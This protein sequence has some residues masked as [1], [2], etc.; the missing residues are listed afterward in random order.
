MADAVAV[1][2]TRENLLRNP[3]FAHPIAP[4]FWNLAASGSPSLSG[5]LKVTKDSEFSTPGVLQRVALEPGAAYRLD[6]DLV[7]SDGCCLWAG[8]G[9]KRPLAIHAADKSAKGL[10]T[11][12]VR[13]RAPDDGRAVVGMLF[14]SGVPKGSSFIVHEAR[15]SRS[16]TVLP[17]IGPGYRYGSPVVAGMASIPGRE[18]ILPRVVRSL[19]DQID[20]FVVYLNNYPA[21]PKCLRDERITVFKSQDHGDLRDNGKFFALQYLPSDAFFFAV[22]DDIVYPPDYIW[23]MIAALKAHNLRAAVGVH[24][25]IYPKHP[26]SFFTRTVAHFRRALDETLPVSVLGTGT[27]AFHT[28]VVNPRMTDLGAGGI[29]DLR[30]G[31]YLK[32]HRVPA[33]AIA[34]AENWLVD[35]SGDLGEPGDTLYAE[36]KT[37]RSPGEF[38]IAAAPWGFEEIDRALGQDRRLVHPAALRILE[39][40]LAM[41]AGAIEQYKVGEDFQ[42]VFTLAQQLGWTPLLKHV[43]TDRLRSYFEDAE[44]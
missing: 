30:L 21:T 10:Q 6:V 24:G 40:G 7:A 42:D 18:E 20:H 23:R 43:V 39:Y 16:V 38:L 44:T 12:S 36:A 31:A 13:F 17:V 41:E 29:A 35:A 28:S 22:D 11:L 9:D 8:S 34:R 5:G 19:L 27:T 26:S 14:T 25:I 3:E 2:Q 15:L 33:L 37:M 32:T 1:D 4:W